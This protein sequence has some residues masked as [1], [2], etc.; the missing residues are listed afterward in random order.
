MGKEKLAAAFQTVK[1]R[2]D[3]AFV[4]YIMAGDGGLDQLDDQL[5]F[6]EEAGATAVELGIA[7]SDPVADGPTIQEAGLRALANGVSLR[8][9]LDKL[10]EKKDER[11]IPI[12]LMTYINPIHAYGVTEFA[13]SCAEAGVD[14]LII[15]D[16]PLEEEGLVTDSLAENGIALI[17][18]AALTST[19]DRLTE[20]AKRTEGFLYAVTVTGTTGVRS[21]FK[22]NLGQHLEKLREACNV[23]VLAGFGVS[24]PEHVTLL[25]EHCDGVVVGSRI[26][27]LLY[28]GERDTIRE[29]I[30]S[31][32]I[33]K[34]NN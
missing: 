32:Q 20:I 17:R 34:V 23:P 1:K 13:S 4:P 8:S 15:P 29:L 2:G 31:A 12:V 28:K 22:E 7:F 21:V 10:K 26:V 6:L 3:K 33:S 25:T 16:L 18:L 19:E 9:V 11:N 14:G 5:S 27:D 24:T 30:Q